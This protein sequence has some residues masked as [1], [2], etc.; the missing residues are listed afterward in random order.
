MEDL[1]KAPEWKMQTVS[2]DGYET[3][4]P[5]VLF[6]RN[7]LEVVQVL[8]RNPIL[9]GK[10][11]F[12]AR[13][14]YDDSNRQNRIYGDWMTSDGAW[15]AQVCNLH[16]PFIIFFSQHF[17]SALPPGGTLLGIGLSSDKTNIS[18]ATGDRV[19]HPLLLTIPNL[20]M[21]VRMKSTY[22]TLPLIA[23][24]PCPKFVSLKKSLRGVVENRLL[25]HCIDIVC[26][27]L[28]QASTRGALMSDSVGRI[29]LYFT[30]LVAHIV[31]TPEAAVIA[32]VG[33]K[34]SHLTLASHKSFGDSFCHPTRLGIVTLSQI[35][36]IS[37]DVD[38]W[39]LERFVKEAHEQF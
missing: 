19:A 21:D 32:G 4:K 6:Y 13:R 11:A 35:A 26:K 8:L 9:E 34:T 2:L 25:H 24:L 39:N 27:P 31:D 14:V 12:T 18:A 15:A 10:W 22:H 29:R 30:P 5:V 28:K 33:G 1:P 38:P 23:L 36:C 16:L 7:P 3:A 20:S 37:E 17:Q